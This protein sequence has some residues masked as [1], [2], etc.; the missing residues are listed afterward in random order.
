MLD[1]S[2]AIEL[3]QAGIKTQAVEKAILA[4]HSP[5]VHYAQF[6]LE[7]PYKAGS[8]EEATIASDPSMALKYARD[9][10]KGPWAP[11]ESAILRN[12]STTFSYAAR[13][14]KAP[15]PLGEA[16][17]ASDPTFALEYAR[18]VLHGPF[19][20]GEGKIASFAI[21]AVHYA[22][23]V[24]HGPFPAGEVEIAKS[25][26]YSFEYAIHV[27]RA[28]FPAGEQAIAMEHIRRAAYDEFVKAHNAAK[29]SLPKPVTMT[30][31]FK[32]MPVFYPSGTRHGVTTLARVDDDPILD[33]AKGHVC[34]AVNVGFSTVKMACRTCGRDM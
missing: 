20:A 14:L 34:A 8:Q 4:G 32:A 28:P 16:A 23:N 31:T 21:S 3:A 30:G 24:L 25:G 6:I 13:C 33:E 18:E 22:R 5:L 15:W 7:G 11:G 29:A 27:L 1:F 10:I 9:V 12:P 17:I 26:S 2:Y 19:P